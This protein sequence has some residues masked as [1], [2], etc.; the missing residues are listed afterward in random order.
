MSKRWMT[1][2]LVASL[3]VGGYAL[4]NPPSGS[5]DAPA[6]GVDDTTGDA[7]GTHPRGPRRGV[8][9]RAHEDEILDRL[10]TESPRRYE[11]LMRLKEDFPELYPQ[12]LRR[13]AGALRARDVD[14]ASAQRAERSQELRGELRELAQGFGELSKGEQKG[15]RSQMEALGNELF[16]LRQAELEGRL[17]AAEKKLADGKA[18]LDAREA[19]RE[20]IIST[21]L[22]RLI[23]GPNEGL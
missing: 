20:E 9:L 16:D 11:N 5:D 23:S 3:A 1:L 18:K 10:K 22:D 7:A 6:L 15:R 12:A 2:G 8:E 19:R 14:P 17:A 13:T 4:A 21:H